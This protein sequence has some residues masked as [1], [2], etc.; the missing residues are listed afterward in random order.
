LAW[1][2]YRLG[3]FALKL[4]K[5]DQ[6]VGIIREIR[7]RPPSVS[8]HKKIAEISDDFESFAIA[9]VAFKTES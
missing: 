6:A 7:V 1:G 9:G 4:V 8:R 3:D 5:V 2:A